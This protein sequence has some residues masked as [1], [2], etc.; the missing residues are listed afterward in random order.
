MKLFKP[1]SLTCE[2]VLVAVLGLAAFLTTSGA[3]AQN[4]AFGSTQTITGDANLIDATTL[5]GSLY[6]DAILPNGNYNSPIGN[7]GSGNSSPTSLTAGGVTFNAL[8]P[9][10]TS[11]SDGTISLAA[12]VSNPAFSAGQFNSYGNNAAFSGGSAAF[13]S[14][15][16]AGGLYGS[17]GT[18]TISSAALTTGHTYDVQIF[19]YS[20][21]SQN[22]STTFMS[23]SSS[24]TL[25]D[26]NGSHVGQFVTGTFTATGT[27]E[28]ISF[29]Q[30][31]G[32]YTPVVGAISLFDVTAAP[33]PSTYALMLGG[34]LL[35]VFGLRNRC[36]PVV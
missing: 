31:T 22:E 8:T 9:A 36:Q 34:M 1:V 7:N 20:G 23:G 28:I 15:M 16:N 3:Y 35:F 24:V 14:V 26:D 19:N 2:T 30:P 12:N 33:E 17:G 25:F 10:A 32:A 6:V 21:D 11:I 13:N 4:V 29:G 5:P 27:S 18:I